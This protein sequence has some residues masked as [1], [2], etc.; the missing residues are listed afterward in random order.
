[1]YRYNCQ[2]FH[3]LLPRDLANTSEKVKLR[4]RLEPVGS[5]TL[6]QGAGSFTSDP[7]VTGTERTAAPGSWLKGMKGVAFCEPI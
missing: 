5:Y 4:Q 1:M 3:N 7:F 2:H 6:S